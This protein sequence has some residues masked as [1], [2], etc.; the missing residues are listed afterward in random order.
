VFANGGTYGGIL[1]LV[2]AKYIQF[3]IHTSLM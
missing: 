2:D 3:I 1:A